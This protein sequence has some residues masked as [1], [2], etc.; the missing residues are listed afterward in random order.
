MA[1]GGART[2]ISSR[3]PHRPSAH[4]FASAQLYRATPAR[5]EGPWVRRGN[6]VIE[7]GLAEKAEQLPETAAALARRNLDLIFASGAAAVLP[8]VTPRSRSPLFSS[9]A[10]IRSPRGLPLEVLRCPAQTSPA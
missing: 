1:A 7:F 10:S 5:T 3:V 4:R 2:A 6:L 8:A 9:Q